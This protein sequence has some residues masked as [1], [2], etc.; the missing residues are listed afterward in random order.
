MPKKTLQVEKHRKK[1]GSSGREQPICPVKHF[2]WRNIGKIWAV[3]ERN[4]L[5]LCFWLEWWYNK[6]CVWRRIEVVITGLTRNQLAG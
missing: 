5:H 2:K 4:I 1:L 6:H 3:E